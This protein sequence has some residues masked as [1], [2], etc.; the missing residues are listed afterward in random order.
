[1]GYFIIEPFHVAILTTLMWFGHS[2]FVLLIATN[3]NLR[4]KDASLTLYQM[5]WVVSS[6]SL[7][8]FFVEG[9]RPFML[10]GFLVV[11]AFGAFR[12]TIKGFYGISIYTITCYLSSLY[13]IYQD[14]PEQVDLNHE[15]FVFVGF[16]MALTGFVYMGGEF[17]N[18]RKALGD[19]HRELKGAFSRI[20]DLAITDELTGLY[21]RRYLM[22]ILTQQRAL[23]NRS[24]YGFVV[25]Y[26]DLDHFKKVNDR[27]GHPFGDK[28]LKA[29]ANLINASLRE[30]DIGARLGGEEFVLILADTQLEAA[31]RVCQRMAQ[32]WREY[33]YSEAPELISTLSAGI[34]EY[35]SPES[36][37]QVLERADALLY[38][39]KNNGRNQIVV[40]EQDLQVPLDFSPGSSI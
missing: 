37:E 38:E 33:R 8:M 22:N 34:T 40:E 30:V 25:C 7:L 15:F 26:I 20:E 11:I 35:H 31:H 12:L 6:L 19:R 23:A 5:L 27:Y 13:F 18:L 16:L 21:N 32:K 10:M 9:I 24:R 39:A 17:S 14:R 4:F 29:F 1:M 36:I 2:L 28:V 3:I